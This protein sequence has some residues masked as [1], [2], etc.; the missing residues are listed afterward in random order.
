ME[1][2]LPVA[3]SHRRRIQHHL[4]ALQPGALFLLKTIY[5]SLIS[6]IPPLVPIPRAFYSL[7]ACI[8]R[9]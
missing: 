1:V 3:R 8:I 4:A 6:L 2:S 5:C 9:F 7:F